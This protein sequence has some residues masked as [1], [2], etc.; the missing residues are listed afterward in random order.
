LCEWWVTLRRAID[1]GGAVMVNDDGSTFIA[2]TPDMVAHYERKGLWRSGKQMAEHT[3]AKGPPSF[4]EYWEAEKQHL[5]MK[6]ASEAA[7]KA[8]Q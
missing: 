6:A 1:G 8:S 4:E 2:H 5:E 3:L 7:W